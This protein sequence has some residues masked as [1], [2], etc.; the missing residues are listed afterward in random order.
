M[1]M[2]WLESFHEEASG[3]YKIKMAD[4]RS[5]LRK[6]RNKVYVRILSHQ[7][8]EKQLTRYQNLIAAFIKRFSTELSS[9]QIAALQ[10]R[11]HVTERAASAAAATA[12]AKPINSFETKTCDLGEEILERFRK[13]KGQSPVLSSLSTSRERQSLSTKCRDNFLASTLATSN[14]V[15]TYKAEDKINLDT[16]SVCKAAISTTIPFSESKVEAN[17]EASDTVSE[18]MAI[19]MTMATSEVNHSNVTAFID[20]TQAIM[21]AIKEEQET[22]FTDMN[23]IDSG[24]TEELSVLRLGSAVYGNVTPWKRKGIVFSKLF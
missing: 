17:D 22:T 10:R 1:R 20:E 23:M 24:D 12:P 11:V 8:V 13:L 14:L 16:S 19:I 21:R 3:S 2:S 18:A 5:E 4:L 6:L 7:S 15:P 9:Q